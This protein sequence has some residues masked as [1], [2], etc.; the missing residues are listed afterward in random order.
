M[1]SPQLPSNTFCILPWIHFFHSP[2]GTIAPCCA[3]KSGSFGNIRDFDNAES[4]VNSP[5]MRQVRLDM[6]TNKENPACQQCYK[7]EELG[8]A[9]FRNNKNLDINAFNLSE[10]LSKTDADG[11]IIDFRMQYWDSRF[12]NICNYRCRMCGPAY[13]HSWSQEVKQKTDSTS[14][15]ISAHDTDNWSTII[16]KYG[17][18]S[19][20]QEVYFAGGEALH[21]PEHWQMLDHLDRLQKHN[22]RITYTTNLSRLKYKSYDLLEY[23]KRF[24]N[25]LFIVSLDG[26]GKILEYQRAGSSWI[27]TKNNIESVLQFGSVKLKYNVVLTLYNILHL[28]GLFDFAESHSTNFAGIDL[29][30]AHDPEFSI[31]NLPDKLKNLA[32]QRLTS[33]QHYGVLKNKIDGVINFMRQQTN[34][35]WDKVVNHTNSLDRRRNENIL[36]VV[37]E[38]EPYW[39]D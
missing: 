23:L 28:E 21:Q 31:N 32:E 13:S 4:I 3:A 33:S 9:S 24:N 6:L 34:T 19:Q 25:V 38:L 2:S 20:L 39:H 1:T 29:T 7:E 18:L 27:E 36:A 22:I 11:N 16:E 30:V 15:V 10:L 12:S 26:V 14:I 35:S 5:A 17:D 8:L 37:P